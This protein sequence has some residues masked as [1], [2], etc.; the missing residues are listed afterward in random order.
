MKKTP[1][2]QSTALVVSNPLPLDQR[3]VSVYLASLGPG[4]RRT[5]RESLDT[6]ARLLTGGKADALSVNWAALR[7]QHTTAIRT[8]LAESYSPGTANKM[9]SALRGVLNAAFQL[10]QMSAEDYMRAKELK[11]VRGKSLPAGRALTGEELTALFQ[12]CATDNTPAGTRDGALLAILR[13]AGLR[14]AEVC[15]LDLKD[16]DPSRFSLRVRGKGNKERLVYLQDGASRWLQDW[17]SIRGKYAGRLFCPILKNNRI[18]A[19]QTLSPQSIY[20]ILAKRAAQ[21]GIEDI[22]PHDL[23]RTFVSDLLDANV[24]VVTVSHLAGHQNVTTTARYDRRTEQA[25]VKAVELL[26][27]PYWDRKP[28]GE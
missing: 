16:Y 7:F 12:A 9:L 15:M 2:T 8:K 4:S 6:I 21:A 14:R 25:K 17:L 28:S 23:R 26:S 10:G 13:I 11:A 20:D 18:L 27:V 24:D 22:S 5:M 1:T 19:G 3:P